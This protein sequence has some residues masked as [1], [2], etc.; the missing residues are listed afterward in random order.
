MNKIKSIFLMLI[1]SAFS[2]HIGTSNEIRK[3]AKAL[4]YPAIGEEYINN[5][6]FSSDLIPFTDVGNFTSDN[7][8]QLLGERTTNVD[9]C[10]SQG[11]AVKL[12]FDSADNHLNTS[13]Y[14][15][16]WQDV[17]VK[18]HTYYRWTAY[19]KRGGDAPNGYFSI[20]YRNPL[21]TDKWV[22]VNQNLL[23]DTTNEWGQVSIIIYTDTLTAIRVSMHIQCQRTGHDGYYFIDDAS[24]KEININ[25][26]ID[27]TCTAPT[28]I[29]FANK[30]TQYVNDPGFENVGTSVMNTTFERFVSWK[31]F[32]WAG[33]DRSD[34]GSDGSHCNAFLTTCNDGLLPGDKQA[35]G[36]DIMLEKNTYYAFSFWTKVWFDNPY[37]SPIN[38]CFQDSNSVNSGTDNNTAMM[39]KNLDTVSFNDVGTEWVEKT[40]ILY[41][42]DYA[43]NRL[44]IYT[45]A[46]QYQGEFNGYHVDNVRLWKA[47][48]PEE[49]KLSISGGFKIGQ[50]I[51]P[52][53]TVKFAGDSEFIN[54]PFASN[55]RTHYVIGDGTIL[56]GDLQNHLVA[57]NKGRTSIYCDLEIC[58]KTLTTNSFNIVVNDTNDNSEEYLKSL[59]LSTNQ[60]I[61]TE[62]YRLLNID[63]MS[64]SNTYVREN[65]L[66]LTVQSV[67]P[68]VIYIRLLTTGYHVLGISRGKTKVIV[69]ATKDNSMIISS[70]EFEVQTDNYLID[71]GFEAQNEWSYWQYYGTCGGSCDDGQ[72][73]TYRRSGYANLWMM[74]PIWWDGV[75]KDTA[76]SNVAQYVNLEAGKY[77]LSVY[78]NRFPATGVAGTKSGF[79]GMATL[80]ATPINEN[81][82]PI[83]EPISREF[84]TSFGSYAYGKLSIVFDVLTNGRY[85][86]KLHVQGDETFGLG[87]Q[88]DDFTLTKAIYPERIE[89]TL[90]EDVT[91]L[92]V[93]S[94]Y[95]IYVYAYY[96]D[97]RVEEI[98][99]DLRFIFDDYRIACYSNGFLFPREKG[100]TTCTVKA[101][102]LD[103][104]YTA[105]F[106]VVVEGGLSPSSNKTNQ[107]SPFLFVG[108]GAGSLLIIGAAIAIPLIIRK[109]RKQ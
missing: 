108:I 49:A 55:V 65:Q 96:S 5:G 2:F 6:D 8:I 44:V 98:N 26:E 63:T 68:K 18:D 23:N 88:V 104:E 85:E 81:N 107:V 28:S 83:G 90:G 82:E 106:Q 48:V 60:A 72:T 33:T 53:L 86:V 75:V 41:T 95:S 109:R 32:S 51:K 43:Y 40:G 3:P 29:Q 97:G 31:A 39:R 13:D 64:S 1:L 11:G 21:A 71:S 37:V 84:D 100:T 74:A 42:G 4:D 99:T 56:C 105:T 78:I 50:D 25:D 93:E 52:N 14:P 77:D 16:I 61:S 102:I 94:I 67:D 57:K 34:W 9:E 70:I 45:V 24:L 46:V 47:K 62:E 54:V 92:S 73:N 87:M 17:Y 30:T 12:Q 101:L 15:A 80:S 7:F 22:A 69:T 27:T 103:R 19:V 36:Q 66:N 91:S 89:A 20:G 10:R 59:D 35:I 79:G 58:G 38:I 76:E